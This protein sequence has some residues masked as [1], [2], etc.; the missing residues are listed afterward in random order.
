[1]GKMGNLGPCVVMTGLQ[2]SGFGFLTNWTAYKGAIEDLCD[3]PFDRLVFRL[4][5]LHPI[6]HTFLFLLFFSH[7]F[8]SSFVK[9]ASRADLH[10]AGDI[11]L[12]SMYHLQHYFSYDHTKPCLGTLLFY[13]IRSDSTTALMLANHRRQLSGFV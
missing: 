9:S 7:S 13:P 11:W 1:M 8:I 6:L 2:H 12:C 3:R 5:T 4:R 10:A